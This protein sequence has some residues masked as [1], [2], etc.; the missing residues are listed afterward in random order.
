MGFDTLSWILAG[1]RFISVPTHA[2]GRQG[3][4]IIY[5]THLHTIGKNLQLLNTTYLYLISGIG[6]I[7]N[8]EL[9]SY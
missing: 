3:L 7:K 4:F 2:F 9:P 5:T 8:Q 6:D 1:Y